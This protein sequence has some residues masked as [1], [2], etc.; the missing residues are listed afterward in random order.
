MPSSLARHR[1]ALVLAGVASLLPAAS[2]SAATT[3]LIQY[4][5]SVDVS[6]R[7]NV[8]TTFESISKCTP[9]ENGSVTYTYDYES[10]KA[11][12]KGKVG[13]ATLSLTNGQGGTG[14]SLGEAGG[15]VERGKAGAWE[16]SFDDCLPDTNVEAPAGV[17]SPTCKPIKGRVEAAIL[18]DAVS[19]DADGLVPLTG[20][21]GKLVVRRKGGGGQKLG[22]LRLFQSTKPAADQPF[23]FGMGLSTFGDPRATDTFTIKLPALGAALSKLTSKKKNRISYKFSA[24]G[25][26]YAMTGNTRSAQLFAASENTS[27]NIGPVFGI[28]RFERCAVDGDG[29]VVITRRGPVSKRTF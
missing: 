3:T 17:S 21:D 20:G 15:A 22:C 1:S 9:G 24:G 18:L 6:M 25:P 8:D 2:A 28:P 7:V 4:P 14:F 26:C 29:V 11:G 19:E 27:G 5:V 23:D 10:D 13:N 16:I 12:T